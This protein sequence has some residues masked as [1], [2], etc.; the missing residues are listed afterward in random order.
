MLKYYE[1]K[2]MEKISSINQLNVK[3]KKK[4]VLALCGASGVI[5]GIRFA[6]ALVK[7][8]LEISV[9][10]SAAGKKVLSHE[11]HYNG[12]TFEDFLKGQSVEFHPKTIILEYD[13]DDLFAPPASGS[14]RHHGMVIAPC[15][16]N[17]LGALASGL[18]DDLIKR[19][20]DVTLKEKRPLILV[21]RETPL[22]LIHLENMH[23][24]ALAGATIFPACPG[25]YNR[26]DSISKLVDS[27]VGRILDHLDIAHD[28]VTPWG[29]ATG[30]V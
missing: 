6:A 14:F 5:Y 16:M 29:H 18:A 28:L 27:L 30:D 3:S 10:I 12:G 26:P 11:T 24:L 1:R 4:L 23:R 15:T 21:T 22:N 7:T 17:T 19:A 25:F 2:L 8:P 20:G 13:Q 9:I